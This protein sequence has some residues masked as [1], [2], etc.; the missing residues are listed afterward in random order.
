VCGAVAVPS[1]RVCCECVDLGR[2]AVYQWLWLCGAVLWAAVCL[3][4]IGPLEGPPVRALLWS[5]LC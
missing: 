1:V 3:G 5:P 2:A 4:P